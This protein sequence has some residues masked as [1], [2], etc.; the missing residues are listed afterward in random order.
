VSV[1]KTRRE[2]IIFFKFLVTG[3]FAT[4]DTNKKM[5]AKRDDDDDVWLFIDWVR[6]YL[7]ATVRKEENW[8]DAHCVYISLVVDGIATHKKK[9]KKTTFF[10]F[11]WG[12]AR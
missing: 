7:E 5:K 1:D 3:H 10:L 12:V 2:E 8:N 11:L 6:I 4:F 9:R